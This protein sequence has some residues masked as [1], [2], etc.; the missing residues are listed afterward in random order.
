VKTKSRQEVVLGI[1]IA[2]EIVLFS[3]TGRN[4]LSLD[5]FFESIRLSAEIG[6]LALALTPVLI[7]GGIDLSVGSM[8]G[9]CAVAFGA[10][11]QDAHLPIGIALLLTLTL[12]LLGGALHAALIAYLDVSPLIVTLGTY[13]LFRGL[14]EGITGGARGYSGFPGGFLFV[15]QGYLGGIVPTQ[16]II[17]VVAIV[18]FWV[19]LHRSIIGRAL[20]AIGH[21]AEGTR[22]AAVPVARRLAVVYLLSGLSAG[23]AAIVYVAHLGQ[24]KSDAGTGYELIAITAVVLGGTSITGG[25]GTI[26]GTLMGLAA[27]VLL[28]NGLRLSAWPAELAGISTGV[29]LILTI[30]L[31]RLLGRRH[32]R[33]ST[34][35]QKEPRRSS[36]VEL[37][38]K[39][40]IA[41][42]LIGLT[43]YW[44]HRRQLTRTARAG[45]EHGQRRV[46]IGVMPKSKGDPYFISCRTGAEKAA[47]DLNVDM[48]WDGPTELDA[49]KQ[50]E[51]VEGWI[52]RHV[53][54]ISVAVANAA[55]IS[56][57]LRKARSQG[58]KVVAWDADANPDARD[59]FINQATTQAIGFTLLDEAARV[60][61]EKGEIAII[62][63]AL[64]AANQNLWISFIKERLAKYPNMKLVSIRPSDDDRDKAFSEAQ[65]ISKVYPDVQVMIV[66]SAP[67]VPGAAEAV[68]QSGRKDLLVIGLSLPNLCKPYVHD[69]EIEAV[70]LWNT[71]NLGYLAVGAPA[72]LARGTLPAGNAT[73]DAGPLGKLQIV[74]SEIILGAPMIFRKDNID[75]FNF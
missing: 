21:S 71:E 43:G 27:I 74:G 50:N 26:P 19:L 56:T 64:S 70:V 4:F 42:V 31:Q 24:A 12:G 9:F 7:T 41:L 33:D 6:L 72:A 69:G 49:A 53:D 10:M 28:Q 57:V 73:F 55:S 63:G 67:A 8:M 75:A 44:V 60:M 30:V 46:T 34:E 38:T 45:D 36:A 25:S 11:W 66:I 23:V 54:A 61:H 52:T 20:Y 16:T 65:T 68:K 2:F 59:Y 1:L 58:I 51:V 5:N 62:T 48:I 37:A 32:A 14:A 18:A 15:G 17:F 13:S 22:Y 35:P 3:I 39:A 47:A 40:C 29:L